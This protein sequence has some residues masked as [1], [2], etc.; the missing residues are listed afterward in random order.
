VTPADRCTVFLLSPA[1]CGGRRATI[2]MKPGAT[3]ALAVRLQEG[4]L[5]LGEAFTFMSGLYFRGKMAYASA[6]G[7]NPDGPPAL[8][9]TPT[10]GL[11]EPARRIDRATVAEFAQVDIA[12]AGESFTAP[13]LKDARRLAAT[14]PDAGRVV[15]LGSIATSKYLEVLLDVLGDRLCFPPAFIGRGDMSRGGLM[16][17]SA[18]SGVELDYVSAADA[19]TR[20]GPRPSRLPKLARAVR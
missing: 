3:S 7:R 17:R 6:F 1:Y 14:V 4:T 10:R 8:V 2:L 5:T 13:L 12:S 20:R 19:T 15:L 9:I 18:A 11:Q 16:L